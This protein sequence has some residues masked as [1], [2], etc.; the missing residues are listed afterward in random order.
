MG[1]SVGIAVADVG[2]S[3]EQ[4]L[5]HADVALYEA[6]AAGKGLVRFR[7]QARSEAEVA[8]MCEREP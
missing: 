8:A 4:A 6:K 5:K 2:E 7:A 1:A 3:F